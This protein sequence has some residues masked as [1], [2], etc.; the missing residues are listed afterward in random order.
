MACIFS[1]PSRVQHRLASKHGFFWDGQQGKC[2]NHHNSNKKREIFRGE[3]TMLLRCNAAIVFICK[4]YLLS[5]NLV[6]ASCL[7]LCTWLV[8]GFDAVVVDVVMS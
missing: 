3:M 6:S 4:T 2:G 5:C 7:S 1:R 8:V